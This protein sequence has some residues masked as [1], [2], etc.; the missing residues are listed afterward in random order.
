MAGKRRIPGYH[1]LFA[2]T[3]AA[4]LALGIW[5]TVFFKRAVELEQRAAQSG[6]VHA[7]TVMAL[8]LGH[9]DSPP[10][11]GPIAGSVALEVVPA[12]ARQAGDLFTPLVPNFP[13]LGVRPA[14]HLIA[15]IQAK[16]ARRRIMYIGEGSLLFVLLGICTIMFFRLLQSERRRTRSMETFLSTVT[17]EM[18]TPLAGLKSMLQT[19]AAGKVP[20]EQEP[21]LYAMGLKETERLE[22]M[23]ENVLVSGR[24]RTRQ[25]PLV[26]SPVHLCEF[27][28]EFLAHRRQ[29]L[30]GQDTSIDLEWNLEEPE[31]I[32]QCD[33]TALTVILENLTDNAL[34]YGGEP[35]RVRFC[36][37][38]VS[39][40]IR[41]SVEDQGIGFDPDLAE[42]L[43]QPFMRATDASCSVHHGTGL[44]LSISRELIRRMDGDLLAES[45]GPMRGSRFILLLREA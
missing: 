26:L 22:H 39:G 33:R 3:L 32:V 8:M 12:A 27:L 35:C 1:I 7:S 9:A 37:A 24:L 11:P 19:F 41:L 14:P 6:L 45:E 44:G 36:V 29:Y 28:S 10:K 34:K 17:H 23:V 20:R 4:L 5:W 2:M 15:A 21:L 13:E 43:F 40:R 38:R 16:A 42:K 31:V 30:I 18:K 25:Y